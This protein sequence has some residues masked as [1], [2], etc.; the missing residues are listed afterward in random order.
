ME[1]IESTFVSML[2]ITN[3]TDIV[4]HEI[5]L[6]ITTVLFPLCINYHE[7]RTFQCESIKGGNLKENE[8]KVQGRLYMPPAKG[9]GWGPYLYLH[10]HPVTHMN[11]TVDVDQIKHMFMLLVL[12][13]ES[14][15]K[16]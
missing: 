1:H 5:K 8:D 10:N 3:V 16:Y 2:Y 15:F 7:V 4:G 11:K 13:T 14:V 6:I 9:V 12:P